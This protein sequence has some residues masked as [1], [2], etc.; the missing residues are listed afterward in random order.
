MMGFISA[1]IFVIICVCM[2]VYLLASLAVSAAWAVV[3]CIEFFRFVFSYYKEENERS[4][5]REVQR[6][7]DSK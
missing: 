5:Q 4:I 1:V 7:L 2:F 6:R 3:S